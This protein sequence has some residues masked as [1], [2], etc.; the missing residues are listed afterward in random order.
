MTPTATQLQNEETTDQAAIRPFEVSVP[1]GEL[2]D[3]RR[4]IIATRWPT[5]ISSCSIR[6]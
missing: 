1:E 5:R 3:L 2:S 6:Q 4:R